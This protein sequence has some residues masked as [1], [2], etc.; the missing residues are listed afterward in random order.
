MYVDT[1]RV[2]SAVAVRIGS[3]NE[4]APGDPEVRRLWLRPRDLG[5]VLR[6]C[7]EADFEGFHIVY[8]VSREAAGAFDLAGTRQLLGWEP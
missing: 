8:A 7:I 1:G 5:A 2:R 4:R 6:R 3:F